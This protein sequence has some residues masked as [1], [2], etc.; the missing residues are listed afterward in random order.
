MGPLGTGILARSGRAREMAAQQGK[1]RVLRLKVCSAGIPQ[2]SDLCDARSRRAEEPGIGGIRQLHLTAQEKA[3]IV[4]FLES[5]T[6][7]I[8]TGC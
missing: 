6:G 5:L 3:E 7:R 4:A 2:V 8:G 1:A